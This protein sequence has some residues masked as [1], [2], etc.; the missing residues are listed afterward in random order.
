[1]EVLLSCF[2]SSPASLALR[3]PTTHPRRLSLLRSTTSWRSP[4]PT[5]TIRLSFAAASPSPFDLS[6]PPIDHDLL[7]TMVDAGA[8]A[9][10]D[11]TIESFGNDGLALD[12]AFD[13]VVV[14]DLTHFGRVRVV[15]DDR[16]HFLHNQTT[17]NFECLHEGEGC[18]T[19]FVTPTARTVDIAHAWVMKNAVM[20]LLS[21]TTYNS[22]IEMLNKYIFFS[23]KVEVND[24][25]KQTCFFS[26]FGP[27]SNQIMEALNLHDIIGQPYGTHRHYNVDGLPVTISVG[28]VLSEDGFSFLLSPSS[29]A[30]VW[31]TLIGLGAVP[32]GGNGWERLRVLQGRPAPGS[33]LTNEFNVLEAGLWRAISLNKGCYK[34]QETIS[35][36]ITYDGVKQHLWGIRLSGPA[37]P[38]SE[39]TVDGKK[40]GKLTSYALGRKDDEHI[41]LGYIRK[42]AGH[43]GAEVL[44]GGVV[45][46]VIEVPF[47]R[48]PTRTQVAGSGDAKI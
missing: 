48:D 7:D 19:A 29:A 5:P 24:I 25:T 47:L 11:G 16:L 38:G 21:P 2:S 34:G 37:K 10:D 44:V 22:I 27:K 28:S 36:L 17:A 31:Q 40:V 1:M 33:D 4:P 8:R 15:G 23:D 46:K 13:G 45:G 6:P 20:L 26:L 43:C 39:I 3:R 30:S 42:Q 35:R 12:A 41:G 9:S 32:M 14:T 18:D